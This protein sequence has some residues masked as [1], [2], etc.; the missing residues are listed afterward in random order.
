MALNLKHHGAITG[1]TGSCHEL[2]IGNQ[3][4]LVDCGLFQGS[5]SQGRASASELALGFPID[6]IRVLVVTHVHMTM[7]AAF[8]TCWPPA[9]GADPHAYPGSRS[10][11]PQAITT[12]TFYP[13]F[14]INL[15]S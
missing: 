8:P 14:N 4:I 15:T 9:S 3:G 5:D 12:Y 10:D 11:R 7:W 2:T 13:K 6:H 1:V